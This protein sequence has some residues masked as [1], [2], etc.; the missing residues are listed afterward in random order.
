MS[1][2]GW[3]PVVYI[4]DHKLIKFPLTKD[5]AQ[6]IYARYKNR[7]ENLDSLRWLYAAGVGIARDKNNKTLP[8][9]IFTEG[10]RLAVVGLIPDIAP[11]DTTRKSTDIP[12]EPFA[13]IVGG[14]SYHTGIYTNNKIR[15]FPEDETVTF[16]GWFKYLHASQVGWLMIPPDSA[17]L[18]TYKKHLK[19]KTY[20]TW[21]IKQKIDENGDDVDM[22]YPVNYRI[23]A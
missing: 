15:H 9:H 8:P 10:N 13:F 2:W 18:A 11:Y 19:N 22:N 17:N 14:N 6:E 5:D 3:S 1:Q 21:P 20:K 23:Y 16:H 4:R 12:S 7:Y